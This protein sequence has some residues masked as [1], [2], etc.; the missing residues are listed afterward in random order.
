MTKKN[1]ELIASVFAGAIDD[2]DSIYDEINEKQPRWY[3]IGHL[4]HSLALELQRDNDR[5]D[6]DRFLRACGVIE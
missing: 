4:A 5:F 6:K 1:Y 3:A 2:I